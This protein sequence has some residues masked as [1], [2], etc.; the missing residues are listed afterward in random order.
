LDEDP[1]E[2]DGSLPAGTL[3]VDQ[4]PSQTDEPS[5]QMDGMNGQPMEVIGTPAH[6]EMPP[7]GLRRSTRVRKNIN[8]STYAMD[9]QI[10]SASNQSQERSSAYQPCSPKDDASTDQHRDPLLAFKASTDPDTMYM[11]EAMKEPDSANF[12]QGMDKEMTDQLA[13]GNGISP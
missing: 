5:Q 3:A 1:I 6:H 12:R 11:H 2:P 13:N 7:E 4:A 10:K 8:R 9:L